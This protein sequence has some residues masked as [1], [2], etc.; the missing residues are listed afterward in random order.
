MKLQLILATL[1][2]GGCAPPAWMHEPGLPGELAREDAGTITGAWQETLRDGRAVSGGY[3]L[4]IG[5]AGPYTFAVRKGCTVTGGVLEP[6]G[7]GRYRI[8]RYESGFHTEGC[9]PRR[10]GPE[11]APFDGMEVMLSREGSRLVARG[12]GNTVELRRLTLN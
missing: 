10:S 5:N 2:L 11:L 1:L 6:V 8:S 9:G 3:L 7:D 4:S 12:G